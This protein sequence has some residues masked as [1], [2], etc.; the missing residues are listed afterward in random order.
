[1]S[2]NHSINR[3]EFL[4]RSGA[5]LTLAAA[6]GRSLAADEPRPVRNASE[7]WGDLP[8]RA[9]LLSV[10]HPAEVSLFCK[11]IRE[12]LPKEDVNTLVVRF[13]YQYKFQSHPE[14]ADTN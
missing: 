10:P 3:R 6:G 8:V 4:A 12:V 1:K 13:E 5:V 9:L 2:M 11:F 7:T 14:L